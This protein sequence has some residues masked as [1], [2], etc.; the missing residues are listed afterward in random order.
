M[1]VGVVYTTKVQ[2]LW[3]KVD[4][5]EGTDVKTVIEKS[6]LLNFCPEID[7]SAQK[8]GVFGKMVKLDSPVNDGDRVEVYRRITRKLDDD[9]D[10][11]E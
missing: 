6:G 8:V 1:K 3:L 7:L 2:Q 11:D 4:V 5:E 9:E 10:E